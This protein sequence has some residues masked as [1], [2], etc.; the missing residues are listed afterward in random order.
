MT[1]L[2]R[3]I[4][5]E[6]MREGQVV[7]R[8]TTVRYTV[9][10]GERSGDNATLSH[11]S[12]QVSDWYLIEDAPD[13]DADLVATLARAIEAS[14]EATPYAEDVAEANARVARAALAALR[15]RCDITPRGEQ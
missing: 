10:H 11:P 8:T 14:D 1:A 4:T 7:E 9:Q 2:P 12:A 5:R 13:P 3:P 6:E 15:E